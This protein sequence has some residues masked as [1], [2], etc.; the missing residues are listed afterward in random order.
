MKA[1]QSCWPHNQRKLIAVNAETSFGD[2]GAN[3]FI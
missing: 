1:S 2:E 3:R